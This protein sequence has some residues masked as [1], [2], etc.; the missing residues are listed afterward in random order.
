MGTVARRA[1]AHIWELVG[2]LFGWGDPGHGGCCPHYS[3]LEYCSLTSSKP[4]G[5]ASG[6]GAAC[7]VNNPAPVLSITKFMCAACRA[8][9]GGPLFPL[10]SLPPRELA[11]PCGLLERGGRSL[12]EPLLDGCPPTVDQAPLGARLL[13]TMF[14]RV[15]GEAVSHWAFGQFTLVGF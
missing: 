2:A 7:Q 14:L 13:S 11:A 15:K 3:W 10:G 5:T 4:P 8:C 6:P 12:G 9:R 1:S